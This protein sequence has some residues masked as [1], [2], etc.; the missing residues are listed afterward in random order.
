LLPSL[1]SNN[2]GQYSYGDGNSVQFSNIEAVDVFGSEY[3][4]VLAVPVNPNSNNWYYSTSSYVNGGDGFD[5]LTLNFK[6]S[7]SGVTSSLNTSTND[8]YSD[9]NGNLVQFSS[10]EALDIVGSNYNDVLSGSNGNDILNGGLGND[11]MAGG[12][13]N[14]IYVVQNIGDLVYEDF[15]SSTDVDTVKSSIAYQLGNNL[16]KLLLTGTKAING[17]GNSLNNTITGNSNLNLLSGDSGK[18]ILN[19]GNGNDTL[20]GGNGLDSLTG[21]SGADKFRFEFMNQGVDKILDFATAEDFIEISQVGFDAGLIAGS[22]I[23]SAQFVLGSKA[24]DSDDRFIYNQ[25]TGGLFFDED[26]IGSIK[27]V[28]IA[29]L[30]AQPSLTA[31]NVVIF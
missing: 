1:T 19:G 4:D 31:D 7:T 2:S 23:S 3:D 20:I 11:Y 6:N 22:N 9:G 29:T 30:I 15:N 5:R 27:Q 16:E 21:G 26:G 17:K 18:D 25:S 12:V 8:Q 28:A 13:G 14:D 10:I 24:L